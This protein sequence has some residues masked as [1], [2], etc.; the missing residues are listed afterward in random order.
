MGSKA[1][2]GMFRKKCLGKQRDRNEDA[3]RLI[4]DGALRN[5]GAVEMWWEAEK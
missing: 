3:G 1:G 2:V 4:Y 5:D